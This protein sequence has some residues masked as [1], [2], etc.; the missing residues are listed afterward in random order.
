M[1]YPRKVAIIRQSQRYVVCDRGNER[2]RMQLFSRSGHFVRRIP[3]RYIDIVAGLAINQHGISFSIL[4][5]L[6]DTLLLLI[7]FR[8]RFLLYQR[9]VI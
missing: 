5:T 1:W 2:S 7:V 4:L 6:Q 8:H 3:I 9:K